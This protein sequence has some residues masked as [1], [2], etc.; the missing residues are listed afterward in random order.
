MATLSSCGWSRFNDLRPRWTWKSIVHIY[1]S[2]SWKTTKAN[3][4]TDYQYYIYMILQAEKTIQARKLTDWKKIPAG[5]FPSD[6]LYQVFSS[7]SVFGGGLCMVCTE[8]ETSCDSSFVA[9]HV[10]LG[11]GGVEDVFSGVSKLRELT[12][13]ALQQLWCWKGLGSSIR[14]CRTRRTVRLR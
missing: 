9:V 4:L 13:L 12:E 5:R 11:G 10:Q 14:L 7:I 8:S 2:P 6:N 1:D 3:K